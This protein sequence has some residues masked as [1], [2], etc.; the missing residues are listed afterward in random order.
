MSFH[1]YPRRSSAVIIK[2]KK[3]L[4]LHRIKNG[5]E[6]YILV[7][8]S[9]EKGET[10]E[11]TLIREIKE[12]AGLTV[13]AAKKLGELYNDFDHRTHHIFLTEI[14]DGEAKLGG[15]EEERN[16]E[17]NQY[18]LEWHPM[19]VIHELI[20]YPDGILELIKKVD[21]NFGKY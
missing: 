4:L 8:G 15:P 19:S 9:M 2:D 17:D 16:N 14:I 18:H 11:Q 3:I 21:L 20:L 5:Q 6:Y 12:E 10:A 13:R 7:G 1:K